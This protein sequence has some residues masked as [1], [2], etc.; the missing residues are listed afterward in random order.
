VDV[1][2]HN[3]F[4][5][6]TANVLA[7]YDA[8]ATGLNVC[9]NGVG[10][11]AGNAPLEEVAAALEILYGV[12]TGLRLELLPWLSDLVAEITKI[13]LGYFKPI[14]GAGAFSMERWTG[15][16][17]LEGAGERRFAFA[18]EPEVVGRAP[19]VV[20]GKWSDAG[21][22]EKTLA[23]L[24]LTATPEQLQIILDECQR[25]GIALHRPLND[26]EVLAVARAAGARTVS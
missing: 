17:I 3:D 26:D 25:S 1:H 7:A 5:M 12:D 6:S 2:C 9:A 8:G 20:V 19:R 15:G 11:R 18:V 23:D 10:Y 21:A 4:G 13:P 22:V 14:V 16:N 24:G